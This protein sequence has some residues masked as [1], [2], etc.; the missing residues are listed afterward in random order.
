MC[1]GQAWTAALALA[2]HAGAEQFAMDA[3]L[4]VAGVALV[5]ASWAPPE[6]VTL[7]GKLLLRLRRPPCYDRP[8]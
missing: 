4:L 6:F 1:L 7:L 8:L 2:S 3:A 5:S